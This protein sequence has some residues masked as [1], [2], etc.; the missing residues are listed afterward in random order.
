QGIGSALYEESVYNDE[1]QMLNAS[2][3]DY[4]VPMAAEIPDI[5]IAD[6]VTPP[7]PLSL[8]PKASARLA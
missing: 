2:L 3:A 4:L 1:G 5:E 7:G 6:V 8:A